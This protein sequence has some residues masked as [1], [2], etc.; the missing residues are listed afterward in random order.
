M[1]PFSLEKASSIKIDTGY[2]SSQFFAGKDLRSDP[3]IIKIAKTRR[4]AQV[5]YLEPPADIPINR[6]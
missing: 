5:D 6:N 4:Q 3:A 1:K 2:P